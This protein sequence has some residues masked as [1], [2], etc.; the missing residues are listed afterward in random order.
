MVR[1]LDARDPGPPAL[2][3]ARRGRHVDDATCRFVTTFLGLASDLPVLEHPMT[4]TVRPLTPDDH[5]VVHRLALRAFSPSPGEAYDPDRPRPDDDR[6]LVAELHGRVVGHLGAWPLGHHLGGRSI[7]A[8]GIGVVV[9]APEARGAGVGGAL[10]RAGLDAAR[11]RG[12]P[13]A[14]LLPLTRHVY[15]RQGFELAGGWPQIEVAVAALA[16]LPAPVEVGEP[17]EVGPGTVDDVAACLALEQ[18]LVADE[19]AG[20]LVRPEPFGRRALDP[21]KDRALVLARRD[22]ELVGYLAYGH[23]EPRDDHELYRLDV[24]ELVATDPGA[25]VALWRVLGSSASAARSVTAVVAPDDPLHLL[26]PE[27]AVSLPRVPWHWM[28]ALL[29][30]PAAIA[31]RGWPD[32]LDVA[33]PLSITSPDGTSASKVLEVRAGEG[34]LTPGGEGRVR[35]DLGALAA[36]FTGFQSGRRLASI[37]R[38]RDAS[39]ADLD[40]LDAATRGPVPWIRTF[41]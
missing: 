3:A 36:W 20:G 35:V 21:G 32:H 23:A 16:S 24:G 5:E 41:F 33:V 38:L 30:P 2:E 14:S 18:R 1:L 4:V 19:A 7:P 31:A 27:Q 26:L 6:R 12:E 37:G 10:L 29:D 25:R 17:V 22:G 9:V 40:A 15:R 11:D 39:T 28:L 8:A 34:Q 13:L